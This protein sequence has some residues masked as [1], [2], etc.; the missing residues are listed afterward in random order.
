M[1]DEPSATARFIAEHIV[2]LG[3]EDH[4]RLEIPAD[5]IEWTVRLLET[6]GWSRKALARKSSRA[7]SRLTERLSIPGVRTHYV[8]RK[9]IIEQEARK[10]ISDGFRRIVIIAGGFDVLALRLAH[11]FPQIRFLELDHPA[12]QRV[13]RETLER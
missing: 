5:Q 9:R 1:R 8:L 11:E 3:P 12:T 4:A 13:K 6:C 7:M 2:L 10:A